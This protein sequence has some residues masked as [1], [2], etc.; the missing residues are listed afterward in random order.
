MYPVCEFAIEGAL[1]LGG[2]LTFSGFCF[3]S[4]CG[5]FRDCVGD[6]RGMHIVGCV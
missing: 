6:F 2:W 1:F 4:F 5:C 3:A